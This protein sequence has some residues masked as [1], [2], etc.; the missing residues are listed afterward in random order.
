MDLS[1]ENLSA[2]AARAHETVVVSIV[3]N[4][5]TYLWRPLGGL[6]LDDQPLTQFQLV[7]AFQLDGL[8][9]WFHPEHGHIVIEVLREVGPGLLRRHFYPGTTLGSCRRRRIGTR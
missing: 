7:V 4:D 3:A 2:W 6:D 8:V 5:S 9:V 1:A